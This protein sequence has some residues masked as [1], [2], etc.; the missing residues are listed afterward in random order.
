M[1]GTNTKIISI[2][3]AFA[4]AMG[5]LPAL[6]SVAMA[7]DEVIAPADEPT[8]EVE[9]DNLI[10]DNTPAPDV[11]EAATD[12]DMTTTDEIA[13]DEAVSGEPVSGSADVIMTPAVNEDGTYNVNVE[14][15]GSG[16]ADIYINGVQGAT[17]TA[18]PDEQVTI[19]VKL[20]DSAFGPDR[21]QGAEFSGGRLDFDT[22]I[23]SVDFTM[24]EQDADITVNIVELVSITFDENGGTPGSAWP[25]KSELIIPDGQR[26]YFFII[27]IFDGSTTVA[28]TVPTQ[29]VAAPA[30]EEFA[31]LEIGGKTYGIG[32][33]FTDVVANGDTVVKF[34]WEGDEPAAD[35]SGNN[36][37]GSS[38]ETGGNG[39]GSGTSYASRSGV[40]ASTS[41]A[42]AG[43][44]TAQTA[45]APV[46]ASATGTVIADDANPTTSGVGT[47]A[48]SAHIA[49]THVNVIPIVIIVLAAL[50][51]VLFALF[52]R[53]RGDEEEA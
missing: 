45:S 20:I 33:S 35:D 14:T 48:S 31:G 44:A 18:T 53:R 9:N 19:G 46:A 3:A 51:I 23:Y 15:V 41:A 4:L 10:T 27:N 52:R 30:G 25:G 29:V 17:G 37:G 21:F 40:I 49:S 8:L 6:A 34:L 39:N 5:L 43:V 47:I 12:A 11:A 7:D 16:S 50:A 26:F 38:A 42:S 22:G 13:V 32:S 36:E 2:V 28:E 24:P 1:K